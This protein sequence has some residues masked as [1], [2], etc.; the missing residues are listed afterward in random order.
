M[1]QGKFAKFKKYT[2]HSAHV[3]NVRWTADGK[4]LVSSG[5]AD[6]AIMVW[7]RQ[8]TQDKDGAIR[9]ES[10]DSDTDSEEEGEQ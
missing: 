3:T 5:G 8:S 4:K 1:V 7:A 9:G 10:D 6:T 2:G